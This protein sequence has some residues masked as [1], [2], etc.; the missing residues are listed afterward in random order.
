MKRRS[1]LSRKLS[2]LEY[3]LSGRC[4]RLSR[5]QKSLYELNSTLKKAGKKQK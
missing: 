4:R 1:V 2:Q 5:I 3:E